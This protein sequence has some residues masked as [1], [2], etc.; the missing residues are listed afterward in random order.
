VQAKLPLH[1]A[2]LFP[3]EPADLKPLVLGWQAQ[4][5]KLGNHVLAAIAESLGLDRSHF[6]STICRQ[7]LGLLRLFHY[8]AE[9]NPDPSLWAVGEH[10]DYGLI[11]LLLPTDKGLQVQTKQGQWIDVDPIP[12]TFIVNIGDILERITGGLYKSTPHRARNTQ[13]RSRYAIP[14]FFDPDW[15]AEL[16]ELKLEVSE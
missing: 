5:E 7:H 12:G 16:K 9:E 11:T 6:R 3:E 14:Y 15:D 8:P 10:T 1:G 13:G 4:M 2:N